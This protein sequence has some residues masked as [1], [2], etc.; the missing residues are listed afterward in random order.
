MVNILWITFCR[1]IVSQTKKLTNKLCFVHI[2]QK[3]VA[4][5]FI[6]NILLLFT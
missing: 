5:L 4:N 2:N 1:E 3:E 6:Y